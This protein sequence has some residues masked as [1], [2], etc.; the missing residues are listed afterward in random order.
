MSSIPH[1]HYH[2]FVVLFVFCRRK[3]GRIIKFSDKP[4]LRSRLRTISKTSPVVNVRPKKKEQKANQVS[5]QPSS[6]KKTQSIH[7]SDLIYT[8]LYT[9]SCD[10]PSQPRCMLK[11]RMKSVIHLKSPV[12]VHAYVNTSQPNPMLA[13]PKPQVVQNQEDIIK[14][15]TRREQVQNTHITPQLTST[16][17]GYNPSFHP[18]MRLHLFTEPITTYRVNSRQ[19]R[20]PHMQI[21]SPTPIAK[22]HMKIEDTK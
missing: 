20:K 8:V 11:P 1:Q 9:H 12:H 22:P 14:Q 5:E 2:L 13:P 6:R 18:S 15:K 19:K 7:R 16:N 17:R 4:T 3:R 10:T 21:T